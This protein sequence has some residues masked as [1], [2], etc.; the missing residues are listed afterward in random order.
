M[1][2]RGQIFTKLLAALGEPRFVAQVQAFVVVH[3][4]AFK[5]P[6]LATGEHPL[7]LTAIHEQYKALFEG[8]VAELLSREGLEP[9]DLTQLLT[10]VSGGQ[11]GGGPMAY[12]L[13][14]ASASED[15]EGFADMM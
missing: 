10:A 11:A 4:D 9:A 13:Q 15:Y 14:L 1:E 7:Q 3:L 2:R 6:A 5:D 8:Q 12:F